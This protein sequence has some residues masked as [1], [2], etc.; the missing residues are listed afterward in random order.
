[1][2]HWKQR[3]HFYIATL[4][5]MGAVS[6]TNEEVQID[7]PTS[8]DVNTDKVKLTM[9][10][11]VPSS[12]GMTR[13][14]M[15]TEKE[16]ELSTVKI[17]AFNVVNEK[18]KEVSKYS[19]QTD[20]FVSTN[21]T[22]EEVTIQAE[23]KKSTSDND[24]YCFLLIANP[25]PDP[26][27]PSF[28]DKNLSEVRTLISY[29]CPGK[30]DVT[31]AIPMSGETEIGK[32]VNGTEF[33][34]IQLTRAMARVDVGVNYGN[35][36]NGSESVA[37]LDVF[38]LQSVSVY[39]SNTEGKVVEGVI[40][41]ARGEDN[42]LKYTHP[43]PIGDDQELWS[44]N[45]EIYLPESAAGNFDTATCLIIGGQYSDA[46]TPDWNADPTYYRVDFIKGDLYQ[47]ISR[48]HRYIVNI[49]S[50][51]GKGHASEEEAL[52]SNPS[53]MKVQITDWN[54]SF[55]DIEI[56]GNHYFSCEKK[57]INL[58]F[59][60]D[61]YIT[62]KAESSV[63]VKDWS[64]V[65]KTEDGKDLP[66]PWTSKIEVEIKQDAKDPKK[67]DIIFKALADGDGSDAEKVVMKVGNLSVTFTVK[68]EKGVYAQPDDIVVEGWSPSDKEEDILT[69]DP[70]K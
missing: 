3:L 13:A 59:K 12:P 1:M 6:C 62:I 69:D 30:W 44:L 48:N 8:P 45:R 20:G 24:K 64:V 28:E 53:N 46:A 25:T 38:R 43:S 66:L 41:S 9:K 54:Q 40:N 56:S 36:T 22:T 42:P 61:S 29:K 68:Q 32:V 49:T 35:R 31:K 65:E 63:P 33:E 7:S 70:N 26:S 60:K 14:A 39:R 19:Y 37:G 50:V 67:A 52:K 18:N 47:S 23:V 5:I 2:K 16:T 21:S 55:N 51:T 15:T 57:V 11:S 10:V 34:T 17:L 58:G 4:A 27:F